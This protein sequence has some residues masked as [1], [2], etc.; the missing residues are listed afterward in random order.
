MTFDARSELTAK[1]AALAK[2]ARP[3]SIHV[4]TVLNV[5][6]GSLLVGNEQDYARAALSWFSAEQC[7]SPPQ[8]S[9]ASSDDGMA[10]AS[11]PGESSDD[12]CDGTGRRPMPKSDEALICWWLEPYP[13]TLKVDDVEWHGCRYRAGEWTYTPL[14]LDLDAVWEV[15]ERIIQRGLADRYRVWLVESD[16][17]FWHAS[18][19]Q[20]IAALALVIRESPPQA[21]IAHSDDGLAKASSPGECLDEGAGASN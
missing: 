17:Y 8:D 7:E 12:D 2:V 10:Q 14:D 3:T 9:I 6:V 4:F 18:L 16:A 1:V 19:Q 5:L 15:E 11:T 20:K 13:A 21:S